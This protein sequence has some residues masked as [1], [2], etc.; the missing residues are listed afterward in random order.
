MIPVKV[1]RDWYIIHSYQA[2]NHKNPPGYQVPFWYKSSNI[3]HHDPSFSSS[4]VMIANEDDKNCHPQNLIYIICM[5]S[6]WLLSHISTPFPNTSALIVKVP[7]SSDNILAV[8]N[9][10]K[11][12]STSSPVYLNLIFYRFPPYMNCT[13]FRNSSSSNLLLYGTRNFSSRTLNSLIRSRR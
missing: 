6:P 9:L 10:S 11:I 4:I 13:R 1:S 8:G 7:S 2:Y 5:Y 12:A 3:S